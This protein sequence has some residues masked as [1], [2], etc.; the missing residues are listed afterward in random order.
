VLDVG[1][2]VDH[3]RESVTWIP[4]CV[5]LRRRDAGWAGCS[6][7][8]ALVYGVALASE[9]AILATAGP[10]HGSTTIRTTPEAAFELFTEGMGTWW[11]LD[12]YS[13]VVNE[14]DGQGLR[15]ERLEF[16]PGMGGSILEHV[17]DGRVLP[18]GEV[19]AWDPPRRVVLSWHPHSLPEPPTEVEVTFTGTADGTVV[20]L[21]HRGWE[22]LSDGFRDAM[23]DLY[24]RGWVSTLELYAGAARP[25]PAS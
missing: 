14:F 9:E 10:I 5:I 16:Q 12:A 22:R 2:V 3:A 17:S 7:T 11:P 21:E 6:A 8:E 1:P 15:A 23:Y 18:W 20:S 24:V 13:R 19:I 4:S 25:T